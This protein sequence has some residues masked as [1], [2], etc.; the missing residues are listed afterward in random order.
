MTTPQENPPVPDG[1]PA[2]PADGQAALVEEVLRLVAPLTDAAAN[3]MALARF[4]AATGWRPEAAGDGAGE[5]VADWLEDVAAVAGALQQAAENPPQDLDGLQGLLATVGRAVQVVRTVPP[6][7]ADLD[8]GRFAEDVVHRLVAD[9]LRLH[10]PVLRSVLLLLGVLV[11][12]DPA[13]GGPAEEPVTGEE[14]GAVRL[15]VA[16]ERLRPERLIELVR[17]PAGALRAAYLPD[18]LADEAAADAFAALLLPRLAGLLHALGVDDALAGLGD[19]TG[20]DLTPA[21]VALGRRM[22]TFQLPLLPPN[23][24]AGPEPGG[25]DDP[26]TAPPTA[27][28]TLGATLGIASAESGDLGVVLVPR[29]SAALQRQ[30]GEWVLRAD[31]S[32]AGPAVALGPHGVTF[33]GGAPTGG[34]AELGLELRKGDPSGSRQPPALLLG[35]ANGTRLEIGSFRAWVRA[36]LEQGRPEEPDPSDV[37][38][39]VV[40]DRAAVVVSGG[41]GDGFLASVLPAEGLRT[42]FALGLRWSRRRG[43]SFTGS[44]GL[45]AVLP[46]NARLGPVEIVAVHLELSA[47]AERKELT[48]RVAATA[49][50]ALGP[51]T[52]TVERIG[53]EA[54]LSTQDGNLGPVGLGADFAPPKGAA[55]KVAAGPVTGGGYLFLDH[56]KEEYAGVLALQ[57]ESIAL[58]AVGLLTT[59]MPDGADG[60]SLLILVSAEFTPLHLGFGFTLNGVGGLIGVNRSVSVDALRA[61]IRTKALDSVLFPRDPLARAPE[62]TAALGT[63]FPP[64]PG[65]HVVGPMARIGWGTPTLLTLDLGL[66]LELPTPVRLILLGRLRMALPTEERAVVAVTMDV[67]G[68]IDFERGEASVDAT[69]YDSRIAA[70]ALTGD[71]AMRARWKGGSSFALSAG[72]FH[73]RFQRPE[74]FPQLRRLTL[75]LLNGDNPRLRLEAY[76]AL[77]SNTVQFGARLELY[78]AALGFSIDGMLSFDALVQL[79]PFGFQVDIGGR[80]ALKRG[81][82]TLMGVGVEVALSG[83]T[84]WHV[85]GK[86]RFEILFLSGEISFDRTFGARAIPAELPAAVDVAARVEEAM[87]D[88]RNWTAQLTGPGRT[89]VTLRQLPDAEGRLIVHPLGGLS[90]TQRVAPL[91]LTLDRFGGAPVTEPR[92]LD[93]HPELTVEDVDPAT[94]TAPVTLHLAPTRDHFAPAQFL[95]LTDEEKL[96]APSFE[97]L[98]A[99]ATAEGALAADRERD[100]VHGS[101]LGHE[102][103]VVDGPHRSVTTATTAFAR[104]GG[105]EPLTGAP[106]RTAASPAARAATR[107]TG[108]QGFSARPRTLGVRDTG[109]T[110]RGADDPGQTAR[111]ARATA[112]AAPAPARAATWAEAAE[113]RRTLRRAG[114]HGLRLVPDTHD[115]AVPAGHDAPEHTAENPAGG[116]R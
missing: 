64:T 34:R 33:S 104:T 67:L 54:G 97:R 48:A 59:R 25:P 16:R 111:T 36:V 52:A 45:E 21:S 102:E 58:T 92:R 8:P 114:G 50:L 49:R 32:G 61:G 12:E 3:P 20:T 13:S 51:V 35:S 28:A 55:L 60:F 88:P 65:R 56:A 110:V 93:L 79:E 90:F 1:R 4:L 99:G 113:L 69:L 78:A 89:V 73:P 46:V 80:L 47:D 22:L 76:F 71:M 108:P 42:E 66:L 72:G 26:V 31:L 39:G 19:T 94:A 10:H 6:A 68:V 37:E 84:P 77:T 7:L 41:D 5:Q 29:G 63:V 57:L 101:V 11:E 27:A 44:G 43:L 112:A 75:S 98:V 53:L 107:R 23:P 62:I 109:W 103:V 2:A 9:W 74:G 91:G 24:P 105:A 96:S 116:T 95:D 100:G 40:A 85:R 30:F 70:F 38:I 18:G 82:R 86:A 87:A 14:G 106:L 83:P 17:D 115:I 15:P 81:S